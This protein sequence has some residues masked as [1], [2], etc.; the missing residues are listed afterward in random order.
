MFNVGDIIYSQT[1]GGGCGHCYEFAIVTKITKTNKLRIQ[2]FEIERPDNDPGNKQDMYG[3]KYR[4]KPNFNK[5][6]V[7]RLINADGTAK[8]PY[9]QFEKYSNN[10]ILY[11]Y[12][13]FGW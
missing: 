4:V 6:S 1:N 12:A 7:D 9:R 2:L 3:S 8:K 5:K 10:L 13:D 11:G